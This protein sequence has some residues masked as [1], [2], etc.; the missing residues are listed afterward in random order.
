MEY[1]KL[2]VVTGHYGS[3]K[4]NFS[5][6]LA[7]G[8][9][10][11]GNK[12]TVID[13]DI[14]NPYFRTADFGDMFK[15]R[16]IELFAPVYANTNL[17]IPSLNIPLESILADGGYVVI[18]VGGDDEGAKALGRYA[19]VIN[20]FADRQ[21][22][23]VINKY[24]YLTKE[25]ADAVQ[26]MREIEYSCGLTHTGL[27]NNSSLGA[28]TT[29][30]TVRSSLAFADEV[31]G[32]SGLPIAATCAVEGAMPDEAPAKY[33]VKRYVHNLWE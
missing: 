24:R 1:R 5:V 9:S 20:A 23:Y 17:D 12:C 29:A 3:G 4:T 30:D 21:M 28:E 11:A 8:I 33:T 18:D 14:V 25:P 16:G 26:V 7:L 13:L 19:P 6:N 31:S 10:D 27:V 2:T 15:N 22:L 32:L